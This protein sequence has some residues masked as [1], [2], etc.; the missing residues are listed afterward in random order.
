[1]LGN[2][3]LRLPLR[4]ALR[5]SWSSKIPAFLQPTLRHVARTSEMVP[6]S[7]SDLN[8]PSAQTAH[9]RSGLR[10]PKLPRAAGPLRPYFMGRVREISASVRPVCGGFPL[11]AYSRSISHRPWR[12]ALRY[13]ALELRAIGTLHDVCPPPDVPAPGDQREQAPSPRV[14]PAAARKAPD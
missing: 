2:S 7:R 14:F 4:A 10:L 1:L 12:S 5:L 13:A 3:L 8:K 11:A 6:T 9:P